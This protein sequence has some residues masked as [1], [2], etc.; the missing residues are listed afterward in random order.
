MHEILLHSKPEARSLG[1]FVSISRCK[2]IPWFAFP[3][4]KTRELK[5]A[6][7]HAQFS[8]ILR[9]FL[10]GWNWKAFNLL[11]IPG[12]CEVN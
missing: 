9:L 2:C 6:N 12:K 3:L 4:K 7:S 5:E 8:S 10:F 11:T 1:S